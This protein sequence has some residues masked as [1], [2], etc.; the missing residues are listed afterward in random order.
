VFDRGQ[1]FVDKPV[2]M[3]DVSGFRLQFG[4]EGVGKGGRINLASA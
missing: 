3:P 2:G 4:N 1:T